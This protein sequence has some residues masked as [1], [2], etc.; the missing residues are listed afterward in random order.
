M[1]KT[2]RTEEEL[3]HFLFV[4]Q[5]P[6]CVSGKTPVEVAHIRYADW[7]FA[8]P[9]AGTS[10]KPHY[11]WTV[12]L[13]PTRHREQHRMSERAFWESYGY[14]TDNPWRSPLAMALMIAGASEAEDFDIA[15]RLILHRVTEIISHRV[16]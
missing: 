15:R 2:R 4:A 8:K 6:C 3:A 12:P 14:D 5:L 7:L 10:L 13:H 11:V 9:I 16:A 1:S